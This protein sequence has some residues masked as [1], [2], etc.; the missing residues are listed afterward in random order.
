MNVTLPSRLQQSTHMEAMEDG[1][2]LHT[3]LTRL[4]PPLRDTSMSGEARVCLLA[5]LLMMI[6]I[7][8][9]GKYQKRMYQRESLWPKMSAKQFSQVSHLYFPLCS[10]P[11]AP[12]DK[13]Q[14]Q[15]ELQQVNQQINQQTQMRSM[16]VCMISD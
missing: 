7:R 13:E 8:L 4:P 2:E 10:L 15:I 6:R 5:L 1:V 9:L 12:S 14:L 16:E 11:M 3:P